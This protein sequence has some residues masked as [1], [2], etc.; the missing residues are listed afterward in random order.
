MASN[1]RIRGRHLHEGMQT[2]IPIP[3]HPFFKSCHSFYCSLFLSWAR[4]QPLLVYFPLRIP[5]TA[6]RRLG[7]IPA[8]V[9]RP[10]TK[11]HTMS[12][13]PNSSDILY[14][15]RYLLHRGHTKKLGGHRTNCVNL[16]TVWNEHMWILHGM[17]VAESLR[18]SEA[19]WNSMKDFSVSVQTGR[20]SNRSGMKFPLP[21][22]NFEIWDCC[23]NSSQ[24][25]CVVL[26]V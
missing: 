16:N 19:E 4:F 26:S 12:T 13:V 3:S 7:F 21:A 9:L 8:S 17:G 23:G 22:K 11:C 2:N 18:I 15:S 5:V 10:A 6:S 14:T 1:A 20:R 24:H 25:F